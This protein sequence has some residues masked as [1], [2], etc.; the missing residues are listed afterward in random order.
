MHGKII[1]V[2]NNEDRLNRILKQG[3]LTTVEGV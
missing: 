2:A 1:K 3:Q